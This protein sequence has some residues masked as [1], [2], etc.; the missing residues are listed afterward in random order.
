ME[1][2]EVRNK[3]EEHDTCYINSLKSTLREIASTK[4]EETTAVRFALTKQDQEEKLD[5][6]LENSYRRGHWEYYMKKLMMSVNS[7]TCLKLTMGNF[8]NISRTKRNLKSSRHAWALKGDWMYCAAMLAIQQKIGTGENLA[9]AI[10]ET[11]KPRKKSPYN[12]KDT[13]MEEEK[14]KSTKQ[15]KTR[16]HGFETIQT[17]CSHLKVAEEKGIKV[18]IDGKNHWK[19][20]KDK[21]EEYYLQWTLQ[22]VK[23]LETEKNETTLVTKDTN[24]KR[25]TYTK[26]PTR[27]LETLMEELVEDRET[28]KENILNKME[29]QKAKEPEKPQ[30]IKA[31]KKERTKKQKEA[32]EKKN[33]QKKRGNMM[34][35]SSKYVQCQ[36]CTWITGKQIVCLVNSYDKHYKRYHHDLKTKKMKCFYPVCKIL[37]K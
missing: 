17:I 28:A 22:E 20:K 4:R 18:M 35:I 10:W 29:Q 25:T 12:L 26:K 9:D 13:E 32:E 23:H 27:E 34:R 33:D 1:F 2:E 7:E 36:L 5:H 11:T 14:P 3:E 8:L 21:L 15:P 30:A 16:R 19:L 37:Y 24:L 31:K 6:L